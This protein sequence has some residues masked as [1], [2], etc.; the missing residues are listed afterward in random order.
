VAT[1]AILPIHINSGKSIAQTLRL[2]TGYAMQDGKTDDGRLVKSYACDPLTVDAEFLLSKREYEYHTG[3]NQGDRNILCY[4]VRQSFKPGEITPEEA[5]D[6]GYELALRWTKSRHSFIVCVHIDRAHIH[7]AIVFNSTTLDCKGK[8]NNFKNSSFALRRLSD[9]ICAERGLSVIKNPK[10]SKGRDYGEWLGDDKP[11]PFNEIIKRKIDE[12]LPTCATFE[13]FIAALRQA[14]FEVNDNRKHITVKVPGQTKP[15][16]L[17]TLKGDYTE[18]AIRERIAGT[19]TVSSGSAGSGRKTAKTDKE[20]RPAVNSK[21]GFSLLIDIQE[22]LR[23]G[24]GEGYRSWATTFNL[25]EAAKTLIF[26][27]ESGV[28][29]YADLEKKAAETSAEFAALSERISAAD[30]RLANIAELQ[31]HISNYSRTRE[32]YKA[33]RDAGY[34]KKFHAEH[35]DAILLHQGAKRHFDSL[36]LSKLPTIN[37]LKQEYAKLLAEKKKCYSGYR[38]AKENMRRYAVAK[39][40][41]DS[42]LGTPKR[43]INEVKPREQSHE[44]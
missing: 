17:N 34:S 35:N 33:Y 40:N 14:G 6:A 26:L 9:I 11:L 27:Q 13:A 28:G 39:A 44:I 41:A 10:P 5:L 37:T 21:T 36:N 38:E 23:Q 3:R 1:S 42:I 30:K 22:K 18:Q 25:K 8:Y 32:T 2:R 24:K 7:S 20:K 31:K 4:H 19:R 43:N 15:W 12:I 29:S 16:R